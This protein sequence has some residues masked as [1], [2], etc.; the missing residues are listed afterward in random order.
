MAGA[1]QSAKDLFSHLAGARVLVVE[2]RYY[3]AIA[4]DLLAGARGLLDAARVRVDVLTVP[5]ALELAPMIAIAVDVAA[6][7]G[8]PFDA[9]V[10]LGCVIRGETTHYD[11]VSVQSSRALMDVSL[12]RGLPLG[13]GVL[14][15]ENEEQAWA[16]ARVSEQNKGGGAAEAALTVLAN[17]RRLA[18][19]L[20]SGKVAAG[21]AA[22]ISAERKRH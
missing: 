13:N 11:I 17:K 12:S 1:R 6:R 10:A 21:A 2:A 20:L 14:T 16:R 5:G 7:A 8:D 19:K 18:E 15:V 9:A 4:D 3:D 22:D